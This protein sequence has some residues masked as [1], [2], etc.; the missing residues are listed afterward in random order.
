MPDLGDMVKARIIV[1]MGVAAVG[2]TALGSALARRLASPFLDGDDFH[3]V[4]NKEKMRAGIALTDSDRW[5]WLDS[6][7]AAL[8]RESRSSGLVVGAC[9]ALRRVY[10]ERLLQAAA[11]PI[12]FLFLEGEVEALERRIRARRHEYMNPALLA[13]QLAT[14]EPPDAHENAVR[15]DVGEPVPAIVEKLFETVLRPHIV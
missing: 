4:A 1:A 13:S 11:E 10:R 7:G 9:S 2:K 14:L 3:P 5:P 12:L 15:V 8:G 6:L